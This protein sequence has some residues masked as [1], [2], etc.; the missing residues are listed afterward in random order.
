MV[1]NSQKRFA[2]NE[3]LGCGCVL[4]V[5]EV[6]QGK[7]RPEEGIDAGNAQ[8]SWLTSQTFSKIEQNRH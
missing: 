2:V 1:M 3:L 5:T 6:I 7:N 4:P 8:R